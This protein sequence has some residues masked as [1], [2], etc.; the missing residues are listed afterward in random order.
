MCNNKYKI[1]NAITGIGFVVALVCL[2]TLCI[3]LPDNKISE[4]ENRPLELMPKIKLD[5]IISGEFMKS[6]EKYASDQV[7][8]RNGWATMKTKMDVLVGK[9]DNGSVFFGKQ[10]Y[11]FP[12]ESL[13]KGQFEKNL[14]Y[15]KT[16][17]DNLN[18][19]FGN[20]IDTKVLIASTSIEVLNDLL[21]KNAQVESQKAL[22]SRA[23]ETFGHKFINVY[24]GLE[25]HNKEY[26][27]Y[28]TDHHWT[29]LGSY[30]AYAIWAEN[31][32]VKPIDKS[33][34]KKQT[35][36]ESFYGTSQSKAVGY[37]VEPDYIQ[38]FS[39]DN[40]DSA[41]MTVKDSYNKDET[42]NLKDREMDL[43]DETYLKGKDKYSY[44][45][46]SNNPRLDIS[47]SI[48]NGKKILII[49]DSYA[50][51]FIPFLTNHFDELYVV[52]LRYYKDNLFELIKEKNISD[53]LF[54]YNVVNYSNDRNLV[55]L[56][57]NS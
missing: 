20:N 38:K 36:S 54:L 51:C 2:L 26:I 29:T 8:A 55:Y 11:L 17:I 9:K 37:K 32:G 30:Y 56:S 35:V 31:S 23:E 16:F 43:F 13:D 27:Y 19:E 25:S 4:N 45:L 50:N 18:E 41:V 57:S 40:M 34:L 12:I 24:D 6:F 15:T 48:D 46:S 21:P 14:L 22:L 39:N 52:D 33:E 5:T 3:L 28:K 42:K 49:K 53:V 7:V 10:G 44:F 1:N 47:S